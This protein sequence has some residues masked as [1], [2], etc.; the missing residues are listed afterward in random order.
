VYLWVSLLLYKEG[1]GC[2]GC[3]KNEWDVM[4]NGSMLCT[5]EGTDYGI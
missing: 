4:N 2:A 1:L 3:D 5:Q